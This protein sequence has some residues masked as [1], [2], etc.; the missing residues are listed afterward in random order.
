MFFSN[1]VLLV[2]TVVQ[3]N[4]C[5]LNQR[6]IIGILTNPD[7]DTKT[8]NSTIAGSYV[9]WLS[10][11]GARVAVI[12]F[13]TP[14]GELKQLFNSVNGLFFQ[15][16][17]N[18]LAEDSPYFQVARILWNWA[19]RENQNGNFYPLWGTCQGFQLFSIL[20]A[21]NQSVLL[22]DYFD[23]WNVPI[24]LQ[25]TQPISASRLFSGLSS[26]QLVTLTQKNSTQNLHHN[27][28]LPQSFTQNAKLR[29]M[30][31][32]LSVNYD[33]KGQIFVST[34]ESKDY[35]FYATQW[36]P[37]RNQYEWGPNELLDH[38]FEATELMQYF[39]NFFVQESRKNVNRF[40]NKNLELASLIYNYAPYSVEKEDYDGTPD[41][42]VYLF[43]ARSKR[44][45][46]LF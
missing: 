7:N 32:I 46:Q 25:L 21:E 30:F 13:D 20:A 23:S 45:D 29:S 43:P 2:L 28:V 4:F 9:Q 18:T 40:P 24:A 14:L 5:S 26:R 11:G 19:I 38:T 44:D 31:Q 37:E 16:G 3:L 15:G 12:R 41:E 42:M 39:S 8:I 33:L 17:D 1:F 6:P 27:G 35:P 10:Q 34:I 36:H 22:H